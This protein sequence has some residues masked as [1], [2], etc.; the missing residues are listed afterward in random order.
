M[1]SKIMFR[2]KHVD[3]G[4][5]A[6]KQNYK[7]I[8]LTFTQDP[9]EARLYSSRQR[10]AV[11]MNYRRWDSDIGLKTLSFDEVMVTTSV[12]PVGHTL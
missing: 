5:I 11:A 1:S 4:Y 10:G 6:Q 2:C 12:T 9:E 8:Y 7:S 3:H